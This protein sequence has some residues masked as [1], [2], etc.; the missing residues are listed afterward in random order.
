MQGTP[1]LFT[2]GGTVTFLAPLPRTPISEP[3]AEHKLQI[4]ETGRLNC[5]APHANDLSTCQTVNVCR[6][7]IGSCAR[8]AF[9]GTSSN[10]P[11]LIVVVVVSWWIRCGARQ[12]DIASWAR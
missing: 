5:N 1:G 7:S 3:I 9:M 12:K 4:S 8:T 2:N 10:A 11:K 6:F